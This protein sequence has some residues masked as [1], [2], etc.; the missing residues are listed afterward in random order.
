MNTMGPRFMPKMGEG[1]GKIGLFSYMQKSGEASKIVSEPNH[2]VGRKNNGFQS[3][4]K[5]SAGFS[6]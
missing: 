5:N 1:K 2:L 3:G 4:R 6:R